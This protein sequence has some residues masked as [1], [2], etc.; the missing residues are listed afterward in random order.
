MNSLKEQSPLLLIYTIILCALGVVPITGES[1]WFDESTTVFLSAQSTWESLWAQ[2]NAIS[3]SESQMPGYISYMWAWYHYIGESEW[4][5]RLANWPLYVCL[6]VSLYFLPI[7]QRSKWMVL[8]MVGLSPFLW[9][10]LNEARS[11]ILLGSLAGI[12]MAG[13]VYV[14]EGTKDTQKWAGLIL[15]T[16]SVSAGLAAHMLYL[17]YLPALSLLVF[18]LAWKH[19]LSVI[20]VIRLWI[21]P[22]GLLAVVGVFM[23]SYYLETL[24]RGAGGI[25]KTPGLT[26]MGF[27]F[28]EFLGFQG[29]GPSRSDLKEIEGLQGILPFIFGLGAMALVWAGVAWLGI[30]RVLDAQ[31]RMNPYFWAFA[32]G[33]VVFL[34]IAVLKD[35][36]FWGR[37]MIFLYPLLVMALATWL[38]QSWERNPPLTQVI[39]FAGLALWIFS[40]VRLRTHETYGK[41]DNYQLAVSKALELNEEGLPIFWTGNWMGGAYYGLNFTLGPDYLQEEAPITWN[42]KQQAGRVP[43]FQR[44]LMV[45]LFEQYDGGY[46]IWF[47]FFNDGDKDRSLTNYVRQRPSEI[48][49]EEKTF[50]II[51]FLSIDETESD[52]EALANQP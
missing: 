15:T 8:S 4:L 20:R 34:G 9:Y 47:R 44:D 48:V 35:F 45:N 38:D 50:Q 5:L 43:P 51:R 11:T 3:F 31:T 52:P 12:A 30:K 27:A 24:D 36:W 28:Y 10:N 16:V 2:L 37:H 33:L 46:L 40:A 19:K 42:L 22:L 13:V 26:N 25:Y 17:L 18:F 39:V 29:L 23:L 14:F 7:N 6:L 1:L 49:L 32:G 41:R 21:I